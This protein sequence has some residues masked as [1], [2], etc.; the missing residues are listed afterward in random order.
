MGF[1]GRLF[2]Y[3]NLHDLN[4]DWIMQQIQD[5]QAGSAEALAQILAQGV[6]GTEFH[7]AATLDELIVRDAQD[8]ELYRI[9]WD[10]DGFTLTQAGGTPLT[11]RVSNGTLTAPTINGTVLR[12]GSAA[13]TGDVACGSATVAGTVTCGTITP[14]TP[15]DIA[16]GGTGATTAAAAR[17]ALGA[18]AADA[19]IPIA[20]GG[21]GAT[22]AAAG[23]TALGGVPTSRTVNGKA[24]SAN[25]S[26]SAADV[27]AM[28]ETALALTANKDLNTLG[29]GIYSASSAVQQ[30]LVNAP[31]NLGIRVVY[32]VLASADG[33][34]IEQYAFAGQRTAQRYY[35]GSTWSAWELHRQ[36]SSTSTSGTI[37]GAIPGQGFWMIRAMDEDSSHFY[38]GIVQ[39]NSSTTSQLAVLGNSSITFNGGN[40]VG[41]IILGGT[42]GTVR[43]VVQQISF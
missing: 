10:G 2:P 42:T 9:K 23:L 14:S 43:V 7:W 25:I 38:L 33:Q 16:H 22:S 32:L 11:Y 30:T 20:Q 4:L 13:I 39:R 35:D 1:F 40:Q 3:S 37:P 18:M 28:P 26:L 21:T 19:V 29:G 5:L 24:L 31:W 17:T 6:S 8:Q 27:D 12:G 41:T 34:E 15:V 36:T